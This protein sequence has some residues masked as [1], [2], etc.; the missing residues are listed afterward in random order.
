MAPIVKMLSKTTRSDS[1]LP[2]KAIYSAYQSTRWDHHMKKLW[3]LYLL[4]FGSWFLWG[5]MNQPVLQMMAQ[6]HPGSWKM[7]D[8]FWKGC[9]LRTSLEWHYLFNIW[10]DEECWGAD[11]VWEKLWWVLEWSNVCPTGNHWFDIIYCTAAHNHK[12]QRKNHAWSAT[13]SSSR[14]ISGFISTSSSSGFSSSK[15][16]Q[17]GDWSCFKN[18]FMSWADCLSTRGKYLM[19]IETFFALLTIFYSLPPFLSFS[20]PAAFSSD[21][22]I[23]KTCSHIPGFNLTQPISIHLNWHLSLMCGKQS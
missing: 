2:W 7:N 17:M 21:G 3:T 13:G 19:Q 14:S 1:C 15:L 12:A 9:R 8:Q 22:F 5:M 18:F 6:K 10:V 4:V 23:S 20:S 11:W 16:S